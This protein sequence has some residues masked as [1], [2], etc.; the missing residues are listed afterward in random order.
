MGDL[1][2]FQT[3]LRAPIGGTNGAP[4]N[5]YLECLLVS[6]FSLVSHSY[7]VFYRCWLEGSLQN[8]YWGENLIVTL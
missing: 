8:N 3:F 1:H 7:K 2:I 5:L 6:L 4:H